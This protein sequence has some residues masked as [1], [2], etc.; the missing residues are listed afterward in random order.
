MKVLFL[1]SLFCLV[2]GTQETS[3]VYYFDFAVDR[4]AGIPEHQIEEYGCLYSMNR[5]DFLESLNKPDNA[6]EEYNPLNVRAKLKFGEE[7]YFV[8]YAGV[9]KGRQ[10]SVDKDAFRKAL[11]VVG[12]CGPSSHSPG[13]QRRSD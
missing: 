11:V 5:H 1:V 12:R 10:Q 8:D 4:V 9:V 7:I 3:N 2:G 6:T 13:D